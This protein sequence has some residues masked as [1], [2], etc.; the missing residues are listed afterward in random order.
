VPYFDDNGVEIDPAKIP[1]P[2]MCHLCEKNGDPDEEIL[3]TLTRIDQRDD[4]VFKCHAFVNLYG[5]LNDA[6]IE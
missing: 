5:S 3:C 1:V 6:I 4:P 2:R